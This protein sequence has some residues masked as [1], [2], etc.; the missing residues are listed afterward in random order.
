MLETIIS[1]IETVLGDARSDISEE[2]P[3]IGSQ[4]TLDSM[5][6]VSLCLRLEDLANEEGFEFDWTSEN[7]MSRSRSIFRTVGTLAAE[8]EAQRSAG[9]S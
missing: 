7:A 5:G 2:T 1:E 3:L 4:G 9:P 6:L 8:Y